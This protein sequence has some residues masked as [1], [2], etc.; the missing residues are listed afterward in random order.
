VRTNKGVDWTIRGRKLPIDSAVLRL[1]SKIVD[2]FQANPCESARLGVAR[3]KARADSVVHSGVERRIR[4]RD[5]ELKD[6]E[7]KAVKLAD[8]L[9]RFLDVP[10]GQALTDITTRGVSLLLL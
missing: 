4:Q 1:R 10:W 6:A 3:A 2:G 7:S 9:R 8:D 5:D